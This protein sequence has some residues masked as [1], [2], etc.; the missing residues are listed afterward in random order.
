MAVPERN[1]KVQDSPFLERIP[2]GCPALPTQAPAFWCRRGLLPEVGLARGDHLLTKPEALLERGAWVE[3]WQVR[4]P[5]GTALPA[6]RCRIAPGSW[7]RHSSQCSLLVH[8]T[9]CPER[10]WSLSIRPTRDFHAAF[11]ERLMLS[12]P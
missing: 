11:C 12:V 9:L 3:S 2:R 7:P 6:V 4:E 5:W 1:R 8:N 10:L